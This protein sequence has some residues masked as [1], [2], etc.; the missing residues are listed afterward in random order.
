MK[1][2]LFLTLILLMKLGFA[3][4][5]DELKSDKEKIFILLK[6]AQVMEDQLKFD[7]VFLYYDA[8]TALAMQNADSVMYYYIYHFIVFVLVSEK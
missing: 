1:K 6:Q 3:L 4:H 2:F 8:A 7:S 5:A